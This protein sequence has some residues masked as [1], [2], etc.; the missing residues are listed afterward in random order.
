[1]NQQITTTYSIDEFEEIQKSQ[2]H[3]YVGLFNLDNSKLVAFNAHGKETK[4]K[5]AEISRA[6]DSPSLT[7][8]LYI[9]RA[10]NSL[11]KNMGNFDYP[12][13]VGNPDQDTLSEAPNE[14]NS[15]NVP[16]TSYQE[17]LKSAN[18]ITEL[19]FEVKRLTTENTELSEALKESVET[20]EALQK[21]LGSEDELLDEAPHWT[22]NLT[23][24]GQNIV[25]ML[26]PALEK[27]LELREKKLNIEQQKVDWRVQNPKTQP[28]RQRDTL[29]EEEE[30]DDVNGGAVDYADEKIREFIS[31]HEE[32]PDVHEIMANCYNNAESLDHF[33]TS[34]QEGLGDDALQDLVS[35]INGK[36]TEETDG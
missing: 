31:F 19:E 3:P 15:G 27:H 14:F 25:E 23:E 33:F 2:K 20:N 12:V 17:A 9:I 16:V 29:E 22:S 30:G 18:R 32:D 8:G 34:F 35:H 1:M 36:G 26:S 28:T 24:W 4:E 21:E 7:D 10:K 11:S 13:I 5:V 6:L